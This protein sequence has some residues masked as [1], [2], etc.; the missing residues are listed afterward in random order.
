MTDIIPADLP[1]EDA[2]ENSV[3]PIDTTHK[4]K[5]KKVTPTPSPA[6]RKLV[7]AA[8]NAVVGSGATDPVKLSRLVGAGKT[9]KS[10]SVKHLQRRLSE[11]GHTEAGADMQGSLGA[12][13]AHALGEWQSANGFSVADVTAEQLALIF[14]GDHNVTVEIDTY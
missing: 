11:L 5:A 6:A 8:R 9:R 1:A 2:T 3:S 13:T 12:L 4:A 7:P 14:E 10:L